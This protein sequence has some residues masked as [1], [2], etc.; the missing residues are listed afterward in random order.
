MG[1][2]FDVEKEMFG[3]EK[4]VK[5]SEDVSL[6]KDNLLIKGKVIRSSELEQVGAEM[7]EEIAASIVCSTEEEKVVVKITSLFPTV[8]SKNVIK[9][10][11]Q[12]VKIFDL[13]SFMN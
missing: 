9:P 1:E 10:K 7:Q 3:D 13:D 4:K 2:M 11:P 12:P 8:P 5:I 6:G